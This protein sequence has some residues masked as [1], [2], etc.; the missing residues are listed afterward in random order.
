MKRR[1]WSAAIVLLVLS[2][3]CVTSAAAVRIGFTS[4]LADSGTPVTGSRSFVVS[5]FDVATGGTAAWTESHADVAVSDG[6]AHLVL[7]SVTALPDALFT[8]SPLYLELTVGG[9]TLAPRLEV[10]TV[11][12]AVRAATAV[13]A[14]Q[15]PWSG[16]TGA[17]ALECV[18][19]FGDPV[20]VVAG[21]SGVAEAVCTAGYFVVGGGHMCETTGGPV[22]TTSPD[23][24]VK[25]SLAAF[26]FP[27]GAPGTWFV[28][29]ANVNGSAAR[30]L[31][32][33][34]VCCR[35]Q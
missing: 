33:Q 6:V 31:S 25:Q 21:A 26:G 18:R 30:R 24:L 19:I 5:L 28:E 7:G 34:A 22:I 12:R 32:V 2:A 16:V 1:T 13:T 4:R 27:G 20:T 29:V 9:T 10:L 15:V 11:P 3:P 35:M 23:C 14:E 17:P 8:D